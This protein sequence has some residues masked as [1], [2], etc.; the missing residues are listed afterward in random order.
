MFE[1]SDFELL[2]TLARDAVQSEGFM[3]AHSVFMGL[4][5][6]AREYLSIRLLFGK[7]SRTN[8]SSDEWLRLLSRTLR[9]GSEWFAEA[10]ELDVKRRTKLG[11]LGHLPPEV[12][13][14]VWTQLVTPR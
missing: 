11:T 9:Q 6:A 5:S 1:K 7:G 14:E 12:R 10:H 4:S 3:F 8:T 2:D 13:T